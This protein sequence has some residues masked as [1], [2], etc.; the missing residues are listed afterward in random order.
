MYHLYN[1]DLDKKILCIFISIC[2]C[3]IPM[4]IVQFVLLTKFKF[5]DYIIPIASIVSII[6]SALNYVLNPG[7]IYS[8]PNTNEKYFCPDCKF[9]YP[10]TNKRMVHCYDCGICVCGYD[11]HCGVIGKCVG[12]FN[13]IFFIG[14]ALTGGA[15]ILC[16]FLT[17][18]SLISISYN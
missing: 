13:M 9:I 7:I 1:N 18:I 4:N 5:M 6:V 16:I 10:I 17:L 3:S 8:N 11:H 15:F 12:K 14:L 2:V